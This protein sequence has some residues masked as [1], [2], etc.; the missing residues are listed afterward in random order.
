MDAVDVLPATTDPGSAAASL[1][2]GYVV[3][4]GDTLSG[5]AR[6]FGVSQ[7]TLAARNNVGQVD[8]IK[9]GQRLVI[10]VPPPPEAP[11][12]PPGSPIAHVQLYPWPPVQ[13]QTVSLWWRATAPVSLTVRLPGAAYPSVTDGIYGW[14]L[15][16]VD[17]LAN[18]GPA[19][20]LMSTGEA[21]VTLSFP[22]TAGNFES[23]DVPPET[24]DPILS[25]TTKVQAETARMTALYAAETPG[26]WGPGSRFHLPIAG[27]AEHTS[28]FGTRRTY[29][30]SAAITVHA[31]EDF[32]VVPGT[33]VLAP[34]AGTVVL[35]EP[36]FVRGNAVVLDHGHGVLT[37]Y[38][39]MR[40]LNVKAGDIVETGQK[41]GEVGSTGMSTGPHLHWEMRVHGVAVD[42]LQWAAK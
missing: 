16:P 15:V 26:G 5:I 3:Q 11:A 31:G 4:R 6:K 12:L 34:A 10:D 39:H 32:A 18:V 35:A 2:S 42:P 29:G 20:L 37:G 14:V 13:G 36:L 22:I 9:A 24:A 28:P 38:W 8:Q 17:P 23:G 1:P 33:A 25:Q 19:R 40:S 27:P 30:N 41:L 21:T 7:A